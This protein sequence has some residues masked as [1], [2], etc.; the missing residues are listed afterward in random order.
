MLVLSNALEVELGARA[1]ESIKSSVTVSSP[2]T[3]T[4]GSSTFL[5]DDSDHP[6]GQI[7]EEDPEIAKD[8]QTEGVLT[9]WR[10]ILGSTE[11]ATFFAAV[12]LSG[13]GMGLIDTFLFIW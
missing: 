6:Q 5:S 10:I 8:D 12:G 2:V 4:E 1:R 9:A 3:D 7:P 13:M 11:S